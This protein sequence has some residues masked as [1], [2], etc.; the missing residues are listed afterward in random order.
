MKDKLSPPLPNVSKFSA[1]YANIEMSSKRDVSMLT[2]LHTTSKINL[3]ITKSI[4]IT[5]IFEITAMFSLRF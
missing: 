2:Q 1:Q 5:L 4:I 3:S